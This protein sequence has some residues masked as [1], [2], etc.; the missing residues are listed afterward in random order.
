MMPKRKKHRIPPDPEGMN[1]DR[2]SW[3]QTAIDAFMAE[4]GVDEEDA[5]GDLVADLMHWCDR[6][7]YS[8]PAELNRGRWHYDEETNGEGKQHGVVAVLTAAV[9]E[10]GDINDNPTKPVR[11]PVNVIEVTIGKGKKKI[12]KRL[13]CPDCLSPDGD[14][15]QDYEDLLSY[16]DLI[17]FDGTTLVIEAES[18]TCD[19]GENS[20]L[21]CQ[22]CDGDFDYP[23][24]VEIEYGS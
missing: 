17:E 3:A 8:F 16:R 13:Q 7:G 15:F 1:D 4:T 11:R 22:K 24:G 19:D 14:D 18:Q 12:E 6:N 21:N 2:S 5:I 9:Y 20:R 23:K 10:V